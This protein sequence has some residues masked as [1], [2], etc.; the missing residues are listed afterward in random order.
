VLL[1]LMFVRP[2]FGG[3]SEWVDFE[4]ERGHIIVP[5][6]INGVAGTAIVDSGA[7]INGINQEF[8]NQYAQDLS[9]GVRVT[10][11]GVYGNE[12]KRPYN[13]VPVSLFGVEHK[14]DF[15]FPV[16]LNSSIFLFGAAFFSGYVLQIDYPNRRMRLAT[17]GSFDFRK[18]KNVKARANRTGMPTITLKLDGRKT[19]R[20]VLDTGNNGGLFLAC[21][22]A[23]DL[24]WLDQY[25]S[26]SI[27]SKGANSAAVVDTF[28]LPSVQ[29]GPHAVE[30]VWVSVPSEGVRKSG[31]IRGSQG[32][33]GFDVMKRFVITLDY[34]KGYVHFGFPKKIYGDS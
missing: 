12:K 15:V 33:L 32:L 4:L 22:V 19:V 18:L 21:K 24:G 2:S 26:V 31:F 3:I 10:I 28:R 14:L 8:A 29:I 11:A 9:R 34:E 17:R 5:V 1:L 25:I 23:A 6:V 20:L 13:N 16:Q 30:D 27:E 7:T